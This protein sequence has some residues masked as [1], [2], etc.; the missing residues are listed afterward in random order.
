MIT[1]RKYRPEDKEAVKNI[2]R[3]TTHSSYKKTPKTLEAAV[4]LYNDYYTEQEP[5]N[6]FVAANDNDEAVGYILCSSDE[7]KFI[8]ETKTTYKKVRN[9]EIQFSTIDNFATGVNKK[10]LKKTKTKLTL[11]LKSK[12]IYY[13]RIRY[14]DGKGGCSSWVSK[15]VK[16]K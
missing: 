15:K 10:V 9:I 4:I 2:C 3:V 13:F 8:K 1:I 14:T 7:K 6:I 16:T 11:K 5:E 12:T